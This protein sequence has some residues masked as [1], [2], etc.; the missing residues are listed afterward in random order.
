MDFGKYHLKFTKLIALLAFYIFPACSFS[1][2]K[3]TIN[4][5]LSFPI[6]SKQV[7][8]GV[9][10]A[11]EA[12]K[13]LGVAYITENTFIISLEVNGAEN[14]F[15]DINQKRLFLTL[16]PGI[17]NISIGD[18]LF[19][20]IS[21]KENQSYREM[22]DFS[23]ALA[24]NLDFNLARQYRADKDD[25]EKSKNPDS[26][27]LATKYARYEKALALSNNIKLQLTVQN[28]KKNP[29]SWNNADYLY[30][31]MGS[32]P[33][34]SILALLEQIPLEKKQ[35]SWGKLLTYWSNKLTLGQQL[36]SIKVIDTASRHIPLE[37]KASD[38]YLLVDFWASWCL[39]CRKENPDLVNTY[40]T[41]NKK[42]LNIISISI[43]RDENSW[44][45]A[46]RTDKLSWQN[47]R[48]DAKTVF[49][50]YLLTAIPSNYLLDTEGK[51]IAK[52]LDNKQ[53]NNFLKN[54]LQ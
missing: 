43:D 32:I 7:S 24:S 12:P 54:K 8:Y 27:I 28:L 48:A 1:Q 45:E 20:N 33:D 19:K 23:T 3:L 6:S 41:Y 2:Q 26:A 25:Y 52:N 53:L 14:Y 18:T 42:G 47:F 4:A 30:G 10:I 11:K 9:I 5:K 50:C 40:I 17:A 34:S 49:D 31:L 38:K 15:F 22:K 44:R 35:N 29:N 36:P 39:P 37:L 51:I 46:I 21:V 13:T 16:G